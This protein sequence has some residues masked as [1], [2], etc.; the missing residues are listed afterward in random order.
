MFFGGHRYSFDE[1]S[2]LLVEFIVLLVFFEG[3]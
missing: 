3:I 2:V 1:V